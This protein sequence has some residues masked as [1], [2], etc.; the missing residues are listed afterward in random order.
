MKSSLTSELKLGGGETLEQ[1]QSASANHAARAQ[2]LFDTDNKK[3]AAIIEALK[4]LPAAPDEAA[5]KRFPKAYLALYF[6][7]QGGET[8]LPVE[9]GMN[10]VAVSTRDRAAVLHHSED[11]RSTAFS[12]WSISEGKVIATPGGGATED[13]TFS[14]HGKLLAAPLRGATAVYDGVDGSML[15]E[16]RGR[17]SHLAFSPDESRLMLSGENRVTIV[18][19]ASRKPL[20]TLKSA[21]LDPD[22]KGIRL[23]DLSQVQFA[24]NDKF[25][26]VIGSSYGHKSAI[27]LYD[28]TQGK[29]VRL[30]EVDQSVRGMMCDPTAT[31]MVRTF[32]VGEG[33]G[34]MEIWNLA[35][36]KVDLVKNSISTIQAM[37]PK[38]R[39]VAVFADSGEDQGL[40]DLATGKRAYPPTIPDGYRV[41]GAGVRDPNG[42]IVSQDNSFNPWR[43][44]PDETLYGP[45]LVRHAL[46]GLTPA[47][48]DEVDRERIAYAVVAGAQ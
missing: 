19:I 4:G 30:R 45:A 36:D 1:A 10:L 2:A 15:F 48:R 23:P 22:V 47:E 25:C 38:G 8:I 40:Y 17:A 31:Y 39:Y 27:G 28:L 43:D 9:P 41:A 3:H 26:F 18:D 29:T 34:G 16:L 46:A 11:F 24:G 20:A 35:T 32:S 21:Q 13:F 5:L 12:L 7:V 42:G 14:P 37:D 33:Y 6:A 44:W